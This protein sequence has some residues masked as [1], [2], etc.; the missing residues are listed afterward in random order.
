MRDLKPTVLLTAVIEPLNLEN[1]MDIVRGND[2]VVDII[3]NL[4]TQYLMSGACILVERE[5]NSAVMTNNISDR[6]GGTILLVSGSSMVPKGGLT[7]YNQFLLMP[8]TQA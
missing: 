4:R 2:C 6:E 7:V 5:P 3:N 8:I 1:H